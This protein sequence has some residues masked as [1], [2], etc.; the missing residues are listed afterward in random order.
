VV[1]F[2]NSY[3]TRYFSG[4]RALNSLH[5]LKGTSAGFLRTRLLRQKPVASWTNPPG[6]RPGRKACLAWRFN[7]RTRVSPNAL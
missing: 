4:E 2:N 3:S 7:H 5:F 1:R 6:Y